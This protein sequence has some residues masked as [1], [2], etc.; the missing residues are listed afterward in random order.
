MNCP[1][2]QPG[3]QA[4]LWFGLSTFHIRGSKPPCLLLLVVHSPRM[5]FQRIMRVDGH[6]A[7]ESTDTFATCLSLR[8]RL[9]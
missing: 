5:V 9:V 1:H 7:E 6:L 2:V 4:L 8:K 3:P